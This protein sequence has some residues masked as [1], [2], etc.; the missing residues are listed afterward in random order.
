M[1]ILKEIINFFIRVFQSYKEVNTTSTTIETVEIESTEVIKIETIEEVTTIDNRPIWIKEGLSSEMKSRIESIINVFETGSLKGD[2][3]NISIY[4]DGS[5][6]TKYQ[7]SYGLKQ[8]TSEHNL[9]TLL[10]RYESKKGLYS[11]I[12]KKYYNIIKTEAITTKLDFIEALKKAGKEQI[13]I[14]SQNEIF[15]EIYFTKAYDFWKENGFKTN[16]GLL[17]IF[18]SII[19]SGQIRNDIREMFLENVPVNGGNE[20]KWLKAYNSSRKQWLI[21]KSEL[22]AKTI[23]RQKTFEKILQSK[24]Y[25]L[26]GIIKVKDFTLPV[27]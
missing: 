10:K 3:S 22:L 26:K 25:D 18:D 17:I 1:N 20:I 27:I 4:K 11:K 23:Y 12:F 6:G 7:V 9:I 14:D 16:L 2:F 24:N 21:S 19:H 15:D 5:N 13:M 8:F